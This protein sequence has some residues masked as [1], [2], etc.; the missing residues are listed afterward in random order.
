MVS[1]KQHLTISNAVEVINTVI[2]TTYCRK[3][4]LWIYN[5]VN[6]NDNDNNNNKNDDEDDIHL[7]LYSLPPNISSAMIIVF[8]FTNR[9]IDMNRIM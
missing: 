2:E 4:T 9:H 3:D 7:I 6:D 8:S 1:T 5:N